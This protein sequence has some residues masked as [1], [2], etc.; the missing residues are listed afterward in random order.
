[1][2]TPS[3]PS[4]ADAPREAF[5][6]AITAQQRLERALIAAGLDPGRNFPQMAAKVNRAGEPQIAIGAVTIETADCLGRAL[7]S[8]PRTPRR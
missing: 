6:K 7:T 4:P 3:E 8:F 2:P 1:M 5:A